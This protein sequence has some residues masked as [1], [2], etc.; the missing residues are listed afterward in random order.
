MTI[1]ELIYDINQEIGLINAGDQ[2]AD[3]TVNTLTLKL[4]NRVI[5]SYNL[6]GYLKY[7]T[8]TITLTTVGGRYLISTNPVCISHVYY[9]LGSNNNGLEE[10]SPNNIFS[11]HTSG[12]TPTYFAYMRGVVEDDAMFGEV[13]INVDASQYELKAVISNEIQQYLIN[14]TILM[15]NEY[16]ELILADVQYRLLSDADSSE[17]LVA[18]KLNELSKIKNSIKRS[19]FKPITYS[20]CGMSNR[21]R[22]LSGVGR[23]WVLK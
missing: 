10:C 22:F 19:N 7:N 20:M 13:L 11:Y 17:Q 2:T 21:D 1:R 5:A 6:Q 9:Q 16:I 4:I 14:D 18:R 12:N 8:Q 15:P 23:I 3:D